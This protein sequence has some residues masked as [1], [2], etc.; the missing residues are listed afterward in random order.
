MINGILNSILN[1]ASFALSDSKDQISTIAKKRAQENFDIDIPSP[2]DFKAKISSFQLNDPR[3]AKK[4]QD[5]YK[6]TRK[7]LERAINKLTRAKEELEAIKFKLTD[8]NSKFNFF[9]ENVLPDDSLFGSIILLLR[10]IPLIIDGVLA[11]QV[12]PVVSGTV[13]DKAGEVKDA[14]KNSIK[15]FDNAIRSLDKSIEYFEKETDILIKPLDIGIKNIQ[16]SI[17]KLQL[18]LDQINKL[19]G[20]ALIQAANTAMPELQ[21]TTTG[22]GSGEVSTSSVLTG[23][24][25]E[26]YLSN[27]DNLSNVV[28][29]LIIP[30]RKIYYEI[31][32]K[33]P[34]SELRE[35]GIIERPID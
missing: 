20:N 31:T 25:L 32:D 19:W 1:R 21:D 16:V 23:T 4:A 14:I 2:A 34:G 30:T 17:D 13:I 7:L 24:T 12:I 29:K 11:V 3:E 5:L 9:N 18:I 15:N 27:P 22:D 28:E 35:A 10:G 33:G 6:K 8:I 26:E